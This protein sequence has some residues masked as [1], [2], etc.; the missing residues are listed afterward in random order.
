[1]V[2]DASGIERLI[3]GRCRNA[4]KPPKRR[5]CWIDV[6][7][8][9]AE[10][11]ICRTGIASIGWIAAQTWSVWRCNRRTMTYHVAVGILSMQLCVVP[12]GLSGS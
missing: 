4:R 6:C 11:Y 2:G 10:R 7:L 3:G 12:E 5:T 9:V 1:M 8:P